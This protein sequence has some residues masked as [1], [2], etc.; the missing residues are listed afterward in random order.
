MKQK[1]LFYAVVVLLVMNVFT[2]IGWSKSMDD[3]QAYHQYYMGAEELLD[4]L[5]NHYNWIDAIDNEAYYSAVGE[6]SNH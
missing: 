5:E 2:L 6:L 1:S 4:T 3:V